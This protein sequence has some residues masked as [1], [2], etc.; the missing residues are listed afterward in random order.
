MKL[1]LPAV[2]EKKKVIVR[3]S[4]QRQQMS[5]VPVT[6]C[7]IKTPE[8]MIKAA[9]IIRKYLAQ[10]TE[11]IP[12]RLAVDVETYRAQG[13]DKN[14][15]P[16]A[17]WDGE[18]WR[19]YIRT[20][21]I[22][23][24]PLTPEFPIRN[25]QFVFDVRELG[26]EIIHIAFKRMLEENALV[27]GQN[28]KYEWQMLKAHLDIDLQCMNDTMLKSQVYR[29]GDKISHGLDDLY[30]EYLDPALFRLLT[31][32]DYW[33]YSQFKK[34]YQEC[35]WSGRVTDG[36][37]H[38]AADD[39]RLIWYLDAKLDEMI[40]DWIDA[41]ERGWP[42]NRG[43]NETLLLEMNLIPAYA[44]MEMLGMKLDTDYMIKEVIPRL[45]KKRESERLKCSQWRPFW[46]QRPAGRCEVTLKHNLDLEGL[47]FSHGKKAA[48]LIR[49]GLK[50]S[51]PET[52]FSCRTAEKN[53]GDEIYLSWST[54]E[55]TQ[56]QT[57]KGIRKEVSLTDNE[58]T[59]EKKLKKVLTSWLGEDEFWFPEPWLKNL[60]YHVDLKDALE[61]CLGYRP[62]TTAG[63]QLKFKVHEHECVQAVLEYKQAQSY[64]SK[65]GRGLLDMATA[66]G[67]LHPSWWQ[68]GAFS[69]AVDTGRSACQ[70]PNIMF[71]PSRGYIHFEDD[72]EIGTKNKTFFRNAF[73]AEDGYVL[74]VADFSSIEP[75]ILMR[76][77]GDQNL[78]AAIEDDL[79]ARAAKLA[80][81]LNYLPYKSQ[82]K[83]NAALARGER[84]KLDEAMRERGKIIQLA[85]QYGMGPKAMREYVFVESNGEIDLDDYG[86]AKEV[87]KRIFEYYP[88]VYEYQQKVYRQ[89]AKRPNMTGSLADFK[90]RK[91]FAYSFSMDGRP[92]RFCIDVAQ[93]DMDDDLLDRRYAPEGED[94][95][96]YYNDFK[97]RVGKASLEAANNKIQ[98]TAADIQKR[99]ILRIYRKIKGHPNAYD[100]GISGIIGV[101]HDEI[102][103]HFPEADGD[104]WK[105]EFEKAM[106][107]EGNRIL[108]PAI[109]CEV[110][111][112]VAKTWAGAK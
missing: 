21:Q 42:A 37:V 76:I 106:I 85:T 36:H 94:P 81:K 66:R 55:V 102:I 84:A 87:I 2:A 34:F 107:K 16:R 104:Y 46:R 70:K 112:K 18:D 60:N 32:M 35:D 9:R 8:K 83:V 44:E 92:R 17:I 98:S 30:K 24:D 75:R 45:E 99:A 82:E 49:Q 90:G 6:W 33:A 25:M 48:D 27:L 7:Y 26:A 69:N 29:S 1:L 67:Y 41:H 101:V 108:M 91:P 103:G 77:T 62:E 40:R 51:F 12:A 61:G 64:V 47:R 65:Y 50:E 14:E 110:E 109:A 74:V 63:K 96:W 15:I 72:D 100:D 28:L 89:V 39:V 95:R 59:A 79:Y 38:Y 93:E 80:F 4:F 22:G 5:Q 88:K 52:K 10:G 58:A 53:D 97:R 56:T 31:G 3:P 54:L 20:L 57:S 86:G 73:I 78:K 11:K 19:G 105:G 43:I 68:I 13:Y 23:L 111:C 71:Q